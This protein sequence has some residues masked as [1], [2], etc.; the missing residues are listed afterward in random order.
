[1][2]TSDGEARRIFVGILQQGPD[3]FMTLPAAARAVVQ[4][5]I[6][7]AFQAAFLTMSAFAVAATAMAWTLPLR[8]L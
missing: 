7:G 8:R 2:T 3:A 6:A 5:Q 1:M 4:A